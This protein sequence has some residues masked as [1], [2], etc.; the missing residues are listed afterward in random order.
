MKI[1]ISPLASSS[2]G[3]GYLVGDGETTL[4]IE[5]GVSPSIVRKKIPLTDIDAALVTHEHSDHAGYVCK[6]LKYFKIYASK[7]TCEAIKSKSVVNCRYNLLIADYKG[8][9][10]NTFNIIPFKVN[11]DAAE[12]VGYYIHSSVANENLV[13]ITDTYYVSN[14]F[15]KLNTIMIECNYSQEILDRNTSLN[16]VVKKRLLRSHFSLGNVKKFLKHNDLSKVDAIYLMHLSNGNSNERLFKKE[17]EE[18]T[19]IPVVV[20]PE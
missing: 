9:K 16:P 3:N 6:Y 11:H 17:I 14:T 1:L 13:F 19:G 10:I 12:P 2:K 18:L 8:F 5:C 7:G 20:C 15:D 4:L